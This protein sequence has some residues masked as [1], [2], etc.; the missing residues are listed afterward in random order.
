MC[1]KQHSNPLQTSFSERYFE[2]C[3]PVVVAGG[4][5]KRPEVAVLDIADR[6]QTLTASGHVHFN[7]LVPG[8]NIAIK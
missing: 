2:C 6:Q 5:V 1:V 8:Q 7:Y 4:A 3:G